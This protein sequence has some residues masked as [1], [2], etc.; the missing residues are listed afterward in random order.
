MG[1]AG[2]GSVAVPC[3]PAEPAPLSSSLPR[4]WDVFAEMKWP[5]RQSPFGS[6]AGLMSVIQRAQG[7]LRSFRSL[8]VGGGRMCVV[9]ALGLAGTQHFAFVAGRFGLGFFSPLS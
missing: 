7:G 1:P 6:F 2:D 4:L 8:P 9:L 3:A 5:G